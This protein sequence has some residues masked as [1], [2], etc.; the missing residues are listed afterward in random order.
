MAVT[1][2]ETLTF[3][4]TD[5]EGST[6]LW[7]EHPTAMRTALAHHDGLVRAA[8]EGH[9][10][11]VVKSTGDGALATFRS[12]HD[13][14]DAAIEAQGACARRRGPMSSRCGSGWVCTPGRPPNATGTGSG[15]M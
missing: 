8:V 15:R 10:G 12:A 2:S 4:F 5:L 1:T 11:R 14:A 6:R 3:L 13:G 9:G 7:E